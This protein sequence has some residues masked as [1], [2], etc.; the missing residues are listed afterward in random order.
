MIAINYAR[1]DVIKTF[2]NRR[3]F[4]FA[5]GIPLILYLIFAGANRHVKIE[6]IPFPVY[7]LAG[8]ACLLYTSRCV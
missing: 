5:V 8:M 4:I 7:Y 3:F 1:Y 6:G 2:R